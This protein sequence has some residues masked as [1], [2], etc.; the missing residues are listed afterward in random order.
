MDWNLNMLMDWFSYM[1]IDWNSYMGIGWNLYMGMDW[2]G[3]VGNYK[4][5]V[6]FCRTNEKFSENLHFGRKIDQNDKFGVRFRRTNEKFT[7]N[8]FFGRK[9]GPD[10]P[11]RTEPVNLP[12][13]SNLKTTMLMWHAGR[14]WG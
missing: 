12:A 13:G 4:F 6:R 1:G 2:S 11:V 7:E 3:N 9:M 14:T 5:G 10:S 8:Y